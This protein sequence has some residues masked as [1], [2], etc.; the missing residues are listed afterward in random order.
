MQPYRKLTLYLAKEKRDTN[1]AKLMQR[2]V[3]HPA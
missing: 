2:P 1:A 3:D